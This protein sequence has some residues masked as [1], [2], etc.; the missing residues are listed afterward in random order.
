ML[1]QTVLSYIAAGWPR[2]DFIIV[3]N[4][5]TLDSN[6]KD[7]LSKDNAFR[8]DYHVLRSRYG[9]SIL[10]TPTLLNFAQLQNFFLRTALTEGWDYYFWSHMDVGVL[11]YEDQ[12][13]YRSFYSRVLGILQEAGVTNRSKRTWAAKF[14]NFDYLTVVNVQAWRKIGQWD[15]FIPYYATDCNAYSRARL[16]GYDIDDVTVGHIF[17]VANT[18]DDPESKFFPPP[19]D[20]T[21]W[22]HR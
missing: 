2:N 12:M 20:L 4:S 14:F 8:L 16:H 13:P 1:Q 6:E 19:S 15:T 18:I 11:S 10:Q 9:V 3:D 17:D 7:L 5:G 21:V 22:F